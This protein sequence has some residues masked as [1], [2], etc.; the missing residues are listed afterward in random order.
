METGRV[1]P[2]PQIRYEAGRIALFLAAGLVN[3]AFG[4]G[5]YALCVAAGGGPAL[6][7][8]VS[9][10]AGV[11]FNFRTLGA[12]FAAQGLTRLPRFLAVYAVLAPLN[13]ALLRFT[14]Y[15]G[16]GP[17]LGGALA[18]ALVTPLAYVSMRLFVFAPARVSD[19][20]A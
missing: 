5:V 3:T 8:I 12:V 7:V 20:L 11:C 17:Y 2:Q 1:R 9:T 14:E 4:Y 10:V 6:S 16:I 15:A 18:L 19:G 13:I